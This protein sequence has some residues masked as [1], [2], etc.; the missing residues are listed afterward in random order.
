[1]ANTPTLFASGTQ[2]ATVTTEHFLSSPAVAGDFQLY[3]DLNAMVAGDVLELRVYKIVLTLGTTRRMRLGRFVGAQPADLLIAESDIFTN[4]LTDV[5]SL[6][7]S[8]TQTFGTSRS[9]PWA[10][11]QF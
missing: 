7:F 4:N 6:R 11:L 3:V 1:M 5:S 9:Y 8:L 2:A 10:L